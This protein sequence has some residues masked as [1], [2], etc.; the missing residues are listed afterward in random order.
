MIYI[1]MYNTHVFHSYPDFMVQLDLFNK[2]IRD[3][4]LKTVF[5]ILNKWVRRHFLF[6][7]WQKELTL[8]AILST[9]ARRKYSVSSVFYQRWLGYFYFY[10]S[11]TKTSKYKACLKFPWSAF[12]SPFRVSELLWGNAVRGRPPGEQLIRFWQDPPNICFKQKT[13]AYLTFIF[14]NLQKQPAKIQ[15]GRIS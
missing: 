5:L 3:F 2:K 10:F 8:W 13:S 4:F 7:Q 11:I 15:Q 1:H 6:W 9:T 14:H 12:W